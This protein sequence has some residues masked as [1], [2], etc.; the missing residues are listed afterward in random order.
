MIAYSLREPIDGNRL[1]QQIQDMIQKESETNSEMMLVIKL[2]KITSDS[3]S[4]ILKIEY[5]PT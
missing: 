5:K 2:Q 1:L 4:H 3:T